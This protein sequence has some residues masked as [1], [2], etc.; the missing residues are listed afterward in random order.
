MSI[1]REMKDLIASLVDFFAACISP[2]STIHK[3]I[4]CFNGVDGVVEPFAAEFGESGRLADTLLAFND[5]RVIPF[6][7]GIVNAG[8]SGCKPVKRHAPSVIRIFNLESINEEFFRPHS[9]VPFRQRIEIILDGMET[10]CFRKI[11]NDA[12][13]VFKT[14]EPVIDTV[15]VTPQGIVVGVALHQFCLCRGRKDYA[16]GERAA[17]QFGKRIRHNRHSFLRRSCK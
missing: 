2:S 6:T 5:E 1:R 14:V 10:V 11:V 17:Q 15:E 16:T 8:D 9:A 3:S 12:N 4:N 13:H 7:T